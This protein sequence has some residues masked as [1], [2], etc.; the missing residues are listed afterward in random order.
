[1][2]ASKGLEKCVETLPQGAGQGQ[3]P[4]TRSLTLPGARQVSGPT[5]YFKDE[6]IEAQT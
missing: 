3:H 6:V 1:M 5:R 2:R 4:S